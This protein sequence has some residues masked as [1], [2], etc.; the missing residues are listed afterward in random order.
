[1]ATQYSFGKVVND[2][3]ALYVDAAD[4]NSYSGSG[5]T[6]RDLSV[7][8]KNGTL[9]SPSG[10]TFNASNGGSI[11]FDGSDDYVNFGT[12]TQSNVF[13]ADFTVCGWIFHDTLSVVGTVIGDWYTGGVQ[14]VPEWQVQSANIGD[15]TVSFYVYVQGTGWPFYNTRSNIPTNSWLNFCVSRIGTSLTL[16][17]NSNSLG[18]VTNTGTWGTTTGNLNMGIAGNNSHEPYR[19]RI[20]NLMIYKGRGLTASEMLQNYNAQKTRFGL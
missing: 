8:R 16:Y 12:G 15:N 19:G 17:A 3:L 13:T 20:A 18:T 14:T 6:L 1:M 11:V 2:G 7:S 9:N 10:P 5:S 4:R